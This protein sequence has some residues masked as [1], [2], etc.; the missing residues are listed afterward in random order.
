MGGFFD[1][2]RMLNDGVRKVDRG[3]VCGFEECVLKVEVRGKRLD[4]GDKVSL[5]S[6]RVI[7]LVCFRRN[8]MD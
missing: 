8:L 6:L 7:C 2:K 5:V 4:S 3:P 1:E